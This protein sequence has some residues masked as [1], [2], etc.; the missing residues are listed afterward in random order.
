M[1]WPRPGGIIFA[2]WRA[3]PESGTDI[4]W[5]DALRCRARRAFDWHCYQR[6]EQRLLNMPTED[7]VILALHWGF[8]T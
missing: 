8:R 7:E 4:V 2:Q 3:D 1:S 5:L 6:I